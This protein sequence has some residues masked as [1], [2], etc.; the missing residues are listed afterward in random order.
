MSGESVNMDA[1]PFAIG[2]GLIALDVVISAGR[3][4][5]PSRWAGGTCGN[6]LTVLSYLGWQAAPVARLRSGEAATQLLADLQRWEV[7]VD[8]VSLEESGST[9]VIVQWIY[10]TSG[11]EPRH[12]F[13]WRCPNCGARLPSY[14][15]VLTTQVEHLRER[16]DSPRVFF[17][18]RLSRGALML[19]RQCAA[20]GAVVVFEPPSVGN[21]ALFR[22][23]W[24]LADVVKYSH[25]RLHD[26]PAE[27]EVQ[28]GP[29]LQIETLGQ[30]GLR[31]QLRVPGRQ[32]RGWQSLAA[33]P[34]THLR[35]TA[36]AGDWCTAGLIHKLFR[37]GRRALAIADDLAVREALRYAQ[38]LAAWTCGFEGPRGGMYEVE[39]SIFV[40]DIAAL[41][42]DS[43]SGKKDPRTYQSSATDQM[44]WLCPSCDEPG[45][46]SERATARQM[47]SPHQA[48]VGS[49][50][51]KRPRR[52]PSRR[53]QMR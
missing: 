46:R 38:A 52:I 22:E 39:K 8:F 10:Q 14:K 1:K 43:D 32:S 49:Q 27:L 24:E 51:R 19:A 20:L 37:E 53:T 18:D 17:F 50:L 5:T 9:P 12:S 4:R 48:S 15:P 13:S 23:A 45:S 2:T 41:L 7:S 3:L 40:R 44:A 33:I 26:L 16:L 42:G 35:D 34:A 21:P 28:S 30:D 25:E 31:Y 6:V 47:E 11:G 29:W 36:G